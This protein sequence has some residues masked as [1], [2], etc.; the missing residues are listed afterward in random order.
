LSDRADVDGHKHIAKAGN[1]L[2]GVQG[3]CHGHPPADYN[4]ASFATRCNFRPPNWVPEPVWMLPIPRDW[5]A[6]QECAGDNAK[7]PKL[8]AARP[9]AKVWFAVDV[10][11]HAEQTK[12]DQQAPIKMVSGRVWSPGIY[13]ALI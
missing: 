5:V 6:M 7:G 4:E 3:T 9:A 10:E 2:S 8:T 11:V 1:C 12:Q 13:H